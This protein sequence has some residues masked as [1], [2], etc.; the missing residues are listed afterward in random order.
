VEQLNWR[1]ILLWLLLCAGVAVMGVMAYQLYV[2][3][4]QNKD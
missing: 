4:N 2:K 1:K 3:M